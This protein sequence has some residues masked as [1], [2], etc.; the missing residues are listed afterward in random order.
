MSVI[1]RRAALSVLGFLVAAYFALADTSWIDT[2]RATFLL[3]QLAGV[4]ALALML[5]V[6]FV[7]CPSCSERFFRFTRWSRFRCAGCG[8]PKAS[9]HA[10]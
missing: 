9:S 2:S 8:F 5:Q 7:R 1:Y 3:A 4:A 10:A 6:Y